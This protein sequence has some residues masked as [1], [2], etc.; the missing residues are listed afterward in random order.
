VSTRRGLARLL[1]ATAGQTT[2]A[3]CSQVPVPVGRASRPVLPMW[4]GPLRL[5]LARRTGLIQKYVSNFH[6][7]SNLIQT[8]RIHIKLILC[9]K[10]TKLVLLF[11]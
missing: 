1:W 8:S 11:F 3:L 9:P 4:V 5:D 6:V 10:I 7:T 2:M